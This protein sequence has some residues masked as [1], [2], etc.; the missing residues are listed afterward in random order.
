MNRKVQ[1]LMYGAGLALLAIVAALS[2]IRSSTQADELTSQ[3]NVQQTNVSNHSLIPPSVQIIEE[4]P[5]SNTLSYQEEQKTVDL[6]VSEQI[7]PV[8]SENNDK[9]EDFGEAVLVQVANLNEQRMKSLLANGGGWLFI[10]S[11]RYAPNSSNAPLPN[12]LDLPVLQRMESWYPVDE[13]GL[14]FQSYD[15]MLDNN[16]VTVQEGYFQEG[17]FYNEQ[18]EQDFEAETDVIAVLPDQ[19]SYGFLSRGFEGDGELTGWVE[20]QEGQTVYIATVT[21]H[22]ENPV[23]FGGSTYQVVST[24]YY[25]VY[26]MLNG[27]FLY[28]ETIFVLESGEE[29]VW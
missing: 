15:R 13:A 5:I 6:P 4:E 18:Y 1:Y 29:V 28:G 12:G 24:R 9:R 23:E 27:A 25:F 21:T 26:S 19:D 20:N 3:E 2:L 17:M 22:F 7:P 14:A 8:I 10:Q 16:G 11:E